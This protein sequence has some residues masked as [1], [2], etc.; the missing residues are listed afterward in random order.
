MTETKIEERARNFKAREM[1]TRGNRHQR[2]GKFG[3]LGERVRLSS[4]SALIN[5]EAE[6]S[7][8]KK[9]EEDK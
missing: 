6:R 5:G 2:F 9:S 7:N 8:E 4:G 1:T 3:K